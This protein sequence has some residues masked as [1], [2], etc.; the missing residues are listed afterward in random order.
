MN[1][2][3][4]S[5]FKLSEM[6]R[7]L[8]RRFQVEV[9]QHIEVCDPEDEDKLGFISDV[10]LAFS[11]GGAEARINFQ[12]HDGNAA[13]TF[14]HM[15]D[16]EDAIVVFTHARKHFGVLEIY[17]SYLISDGVLVF[18]YE[19][20]FMPVLAATHSKQAQSLG[21]LIDSGILEGDTSML[22][23]PLNKKMTN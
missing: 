5:D 14:H 4:P 6:Q 17:P 22:L 10:D 12:G 8:L 1:I 9:L 11:V 13:I 2:G 15:C 3:D 16:P 23:P 18:S 7:E 19:A 21:R 20:E